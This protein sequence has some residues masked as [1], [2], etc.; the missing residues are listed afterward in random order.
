MAA[1]HRGQNNFWNHPATI[2]TKHF[3]TFE[4]LYIIHYM[5]HSCGNSCLYR[6]PFCQCSVTAVTTTCPLAISLCWEKKQTQM[7]LN[8]TH[9]SVD[10]TKSATDSAAHPSPCNPD[11]NSL[12]SDQSDG[13]RKSA[14]NQSDGNTS[15]Q[16]HRGHFYQ[17]VLKNLQ[18]SSVQKFCLRPLSLY[19]SGINYPTINS[20]Q[21]EFMW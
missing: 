9:N 17:I 1:L 4:F 20:L 6:T 5:N 3:K 21:I 2:H 16:R 19:A 12:A 18:R 8:L 14:S 13:S 11:L 15:W 7:Y 10:R